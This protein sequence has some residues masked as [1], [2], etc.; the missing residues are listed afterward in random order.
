MSTKKLKSP[1]RERKPIRHA[2]PGSPP[3][4][5]AV[6]PSAPPP[7]I[8]VLQYSPAAVRE[9]EI[10]EVYEIKK[11][12]GKLPVTWISVQGLGDTNLLKQIGEVLGLHS[13]ALED[14]VNVHQRAKADLFEDYLFIVLRMV[15]LADE[16]ETEQLSLF[17][18][19][20]FVISFQ[21]SGG[22]GLETLR[23]RI[24]MGRGRIRNQGADYLA[25]AILDTA[26][27]GYYPPLEEYGERLEALEEAILEHPIHTPVLRIHAIKRELLQMRRAVWP[28]RD[29]INDLLRD[30]IPLITPDTRLYL[31][32]CYDHVVQL[33]DL[34]ETDR[35][36]GS[37]MMDLHLTSASNRMNEIMKVLTI[38]TTI[39]MPMSFI[40]GL[41]GMNFH[42]EAS[43]WNM[44]ELD[45]YWGY[46]FA[47][48]LMAAV[49][50]GLLGFFRW[51][52]WVERL[53]SGGKHE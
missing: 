24:R 28:L 44:P 5:L 22:D 32:D 33:I 6:D 16:L 34:V 29:M 42:H 15:H 50:A 21:E 48:A 1:H 31:K 10:T 14:V 38:I 9:Q 46:P 20:G 43:P 51:R 26:I 23:D 2:P 7:S 19:K 12:I 47:L 53:A 17:L 40:A 4:T 52:G 30:P 35:E 13:L 39:F 36:L 11:L 37:D 18:G 8:R 3:G 25:Y 45:W 41:Y 49:A 27:D